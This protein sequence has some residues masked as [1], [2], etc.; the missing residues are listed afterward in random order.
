MRAETNL[1]GYAECS[2][3]WLI[4]QLSINAADATLSASSAITASVAAH[5]TAVWR[6]RRN[7]EAK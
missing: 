5:G 3:D 2:H 7:P 4:K 1:F 6:L